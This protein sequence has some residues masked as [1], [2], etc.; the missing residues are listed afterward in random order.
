M[1]AKIDRRGFLGCIV[2]VATAAG[3]GSDPSPASGAPPVDDGARFFP[4]G[5]ASGDPRPT[6]V[7]LWTRIEDPELAGEDVPLSLE[8]ATDAGFANVVATQTGLVAK[9]E[10]DGTLKVKVTGLAPST[11][12]WFR[13]VHVPGG[14]RLGSPVGRTKTAPAAGDARVVRFAIASCQDFGGRYYHTW[15][16]LLAVDPDLDAVVFLGDYIYE[17]TGDPQFQST[18]GGRTVTLTDREGAITLGDPARPFQAAKSLA[19]YRE[20]YKTYRSDEQLRGV[21]ARWPLVVT[22]DDHEF[23]DDSFGATATYFAGRLPETDEARK[24]AAE[25][26]FFEYMPIDPDDATGGALDA[27][28]SPV[29]PATKIWRGLEFG[30]TARL[31]VTD[32]R[33]FRPDHAIP[34]DAYPGTVFLDAEAMAAAGLAEKFSSDSFAYVDIDDPAYGAEKFFLTE[35]TK[36]LGTRA[37]LTEAEAAARAE[38]VVK[39]KLALVFANAVLTNPA[40]GGTAIPP[41]GKP[42]GLAWVHFGKRD[43]YASRGS[44]YIV[45][46]DTFDAWMAVRY[47]QTKGESEAIFGKAQEDWLKAQLTAPGVSWKIVVTSISPTSMVLDLREKTDIDDASLRN[48]FY[49]NVDQW[50]G[51]P[52]KR[53]ELVEAGGEGT[54]FVA[55]DIHAGFVSTD[56]KTAAVTTPAISSGTFQE[57]VGKTVEA[58]GYPKDTAIY[59]YAVTELDATFRAGNT[60]IAHVDTTHH[61]VTVIE[62]GETEATVTF[63]LVPTTEIGKPYSAAAEIDA[64]ATTKVFAISRTGAIRAV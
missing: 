13:F 20:L 14:R 58:A 12:Y 32:T 35:A 45:L 48:R 44:R 59:K 33:S 57:L 52:N 24:R 2:I 63:H 40:V 51:F 7:V 41:E 61:G 16:R 30:A 34:E 46:K 5:I 39:G 21:H 11:A 17:T 29:F 15:R 56:G 31:L 38:A 43:L 42:R 60:A 37:G 62:L 53:R 27:A 1:S 50:D 26:A 4:Q 18:G 6:S 54:L 47:A 49:A 3:C 64:K 9:A 28:A 8:V 19:N 23:S 25:R 22:W 36:V 10:N 55:G